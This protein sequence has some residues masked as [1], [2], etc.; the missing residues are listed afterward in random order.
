MVSPARDNCADICE[1]GLKISW[2]RITCSVQMTHH[3][4]EVIAEARKLAVIQAADVAGF[5]LSRD[6]SVLIEEQGAAQMN[7]TQSERLGASYEAFVF[8]RC[9]A[10]VKLPISRFF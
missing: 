10:D 5:W 1:Q 7:C 8:R 2:Q 6:F 4:I 9:Q 3:L